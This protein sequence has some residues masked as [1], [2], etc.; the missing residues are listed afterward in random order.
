MVLISLLQTRS[1]GVLKDIIHSRLKQCVYTLAWTKCLWAV[2]K[3]IKPLKASVCTKPAGGRTIGDT[4]AFDCK[5]GSY[6]WSD[7]LVFI[8]I[9]CAMAAKYIL[10]KINAWPCVLY[11]NWDTISYR[12]IKYQQWAR[13]SWASFASSIYGKNLL[14]RVENRRMSAISRIGDWLIS[15]CTGMCWHCQLDPSGWPNYGEYRQVWLRWRWN[16]TLYWWI[17]DLWQQA[18]AERI[19]P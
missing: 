1:C 13:P 14:D 12:L 17:Q 5:N 2:T 18:R 9:L 10:H 8:C 7:Y 19:H 6:R 15:I 16:L 11:E 4:L 3:V